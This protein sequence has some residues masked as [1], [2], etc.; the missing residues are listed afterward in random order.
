MT[1][2][3]IGCVTQRGATWQ[4]IDRR[5]GSVLGK[6]AT[7][8]E[9]WCRADELG[10]EAITSKVTP[11]EA[12]L[13]PPSALLAEAERDA[14]LLIYTDGACAPN[15]GSGGWAFV[16]T[17]GESIVAERSGGYPQ[18][19][20]NRMELT[21][22]LRALEWMR[23]HSATGKIITNSEYLLNGVIKWAPKWKKNG[24]LK[25]GK[26]IPNAD[27]WQAIDDAKDGLDL[28]FEWTRSHV[29]NRGNE[30]ADKLAAVG[31]R[32]GDAQGHPLRL[33]P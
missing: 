13:A 28:S 21:A 30:R 19:T 7:R 32:E 3:N 33:V 24:W 25:K 5:D 18:T 15:P 20:N 17:R 16:V 2:R 9:A 11:P 14:S 31:R 4:A 6:F 23:K 22:A 27:L 1:Y 10:T 8:Q 12:A 26:P 29:G